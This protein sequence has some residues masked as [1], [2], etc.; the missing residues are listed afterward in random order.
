MLK[1][2]VGSRGRLCDDEAMNS[3]SHL[4]AAFA[5]FGL[6]LASAG[7]SADS[8]SYVEVEGSGTGP[9]AGELPSNRSTLPLLTGVL[10][11]VS[12]HN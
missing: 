11:Q 10:F 6:V 3:I 2:P 12:D 4:V 7:V 1:A 9:G 5:V 8:I